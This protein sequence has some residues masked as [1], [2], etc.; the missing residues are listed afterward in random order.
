M[1]RTDIGRMRDIATFTTD[2][3]DAFIQAA[4][5]L[6]NRYVVPAND[7]LMSDEELTVLETFL[8]V[9]FVKVE[10]PD[11]SRESVSG[12]EGGGVSTSWNRERELGLYN[13]VYGQ[14]A[15]ILDATGTL[16]S[17]NEKGSVFV[18]LEAISIYEKPPYV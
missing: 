16:K 1:A 18:G 3:V 5:I 14:Q 17:L 13:T 15:V 10:E 12:P 9:H 2:S 7:G 8:A 6:I 11:P 4:N